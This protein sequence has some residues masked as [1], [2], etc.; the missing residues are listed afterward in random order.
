MLSDATQF[1]HMNTGLVKM[2]AGTVPKVGV[3]I[4]DDL[5]IKTL[6]SRS[7]EKL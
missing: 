4:A 2:H 1:V 5:V 3:S 6:I 7:Y